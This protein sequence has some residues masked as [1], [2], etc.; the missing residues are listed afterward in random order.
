MLGHL[1][2]DYPIE[3]LI[4]TS[5]DLLCSSHKWNRR[6]IINTRSNF[7]DLLFSL[8]IGFEDQFDV[9][10]IRQICI[11]CITGG[12]LTLERQTIKE[13]KDIAS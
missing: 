9:K 5:V 13:E 2:S 10:L 6:F 12:T 1:K 4:I 11:Q 7:F 3:N 8:R